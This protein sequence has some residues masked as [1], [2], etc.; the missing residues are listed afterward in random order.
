MELRRQV[1]TSDDDAD[2]R[3]D[4][5]PVRP[6]FTA[7]MILLGGIW[8]GAGIY[9]NALGLIGN[10]AQAPRGTLFAVDRSTGAEKSLA[11]QP[12]FIVNNQQV[13]LA[14]ARAGFGAAL[15]ISVGVAD[16]LKAGELV[17]LGPDYEFGCVV[18]RVL[19]RDPLPSRA[20]IAL[21]D[22]LVQPI[23]FFF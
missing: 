17:R 20:A 4:G 12:R 18:L 23:G 1:Y 3:K 21:R 8:T 9:L 16:A 15:L 19:M 7:A 13:A 2:G 6:A 10:E 11:V 14:L 5:L 22:F